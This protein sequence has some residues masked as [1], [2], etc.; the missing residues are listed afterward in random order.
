[1]SG[2][3]FTADTLKATPYNWSLADLIKSGYSYSTLI[4]SGFTINQTTLTG[5]DAA[6]LKAWSLV[7]LVNLGY[8]YDTLSSIFK[9]VYTYTNSSIGMTHSP[10]GSSSDNSIYSNTII[11]SLINSR[12]SYNTLTTYN[13]LTNAKFPITVTILTGIGVSSTNANFTATSLKALGWSITDLYMNGTGYTLSQVIVAK[14]TYS[15]IATKYTVN[16]TTLSSAGYD[17]STTTIKS[18][19]IKKLQAL[20][21]TSDDLLNCGLIIRPG[22][23]SLGD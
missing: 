22:G 20:G 6:F 18:D 16:L 19:T 1:L 4:S 5:I 17:S 9:F 2:L 21:W 7:D 23:V 12:V 10:V 15:V 8:S 13:T 14:F 11:N 3:G